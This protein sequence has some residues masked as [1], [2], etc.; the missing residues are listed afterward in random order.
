MDVEVGFR[1]AFLSTTVSANVPRWYVVYTYPRHER[2]VADQLAHKSVEAFLP[3][4][5]KTSRWKDRRVK[6]ELPLFPGYVFMRI[7]ID[8]KL[9]ALSIPSVIRILSFN[10]APAPLN[11]ADIDAVR[12]CI[13][14]GAMLQPHSF[15]AIGE[16]VRVRKGVFEGLEGIV[17]RHR[18][19]CKLVVT[20]AL[21]QKAVALELDADCLEHVRPSLAASSANPSHGTLQ[22]Q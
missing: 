3:T 5:T 16:R 13:G 18:N 22:I 17:V 10:G 21:I 12:L 20:I 15:I 4:Y 11:D 2:A 14:R 9:K 1:S 7:C 8:Q 6:L 19:S